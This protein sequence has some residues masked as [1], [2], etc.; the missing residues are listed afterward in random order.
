MK[1]I[2]EIIKDMEI[3]SEQVTTTVNDGKMDITSEEAEKELTALVGDTPTVEDP[4]LGVACCVVT[5]PNAFN[6]P[7]T[8][9]TDPTVPVANQNIIF[10][11]TN[12]ACCVNSITLTCSATD[13]PTSTFQVPAFEVRIVG[14]IPFIANV[15]PISGSADPDNTTCEAIPG[16]TRICCS[17]NLC[18]NKRIGVYATEAEAMAICN[19]PTLLNCTNITAGLVAKKLILCNANGQVVQFSVTFNSVAGNC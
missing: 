8:S 1:N 10:T 16:T 18:V 6:I 13:C 5:V 12:L 15:F 17:D 9:G 14:C 11:T 7:V 4:I 2:Q 3:L 19:D